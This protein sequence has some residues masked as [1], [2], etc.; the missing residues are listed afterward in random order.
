MVWMLR[1]GGR[2]AGGDLRIP[3]S[4]ASRVI[5]GRGGEGRGRA[6]A[7]VLVLGEAGM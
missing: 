6:L 3:P 2:E 4:R 5:W 1:R 7:G